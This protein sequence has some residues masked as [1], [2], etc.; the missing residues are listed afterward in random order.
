LLRRLRGP[1]GLAEQPINA[2]WEHT[3][4]AANPE[5]LQIAAPER[6]QN[7]FVTKPEAARR[8]IQAH[9]NLVGHFKNL[10]AQTRNLRY[11]LRYPISQVTGCQAFE[12]EVVVDRKTLCAAT[13]VDFGTLGVWISRGYIPHITPDAP[14]RRRDF[15]V[16]DATHVAIMAE[17]SA[18][19]MGA[20]AAGGAAKDA[21]N[22]LLG[23]P[24]YQNR[25]YP[26]V[27]L[28]REGRNLVTYPFVTD[29]Y[30]RQHLDGYT[31]RPGVYIVIDAMQI[32]KKM[33]QAEDEWQQRRAAAAGVADGPPR[34]TRAR[35]Y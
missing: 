33:Q 27:L 32:F 5:P 26:R 17:L 1:I 25:R 8:L 29:D 15:A 21:C 24:G 9:R 7:N 31:E 6:I 4:K 35:R 14:G 2:A 34:R 13:G 16:E 12:G 18:V 28:V 23:H 22:A 19:G 20:P 10:L 11:S 3:I 30:P